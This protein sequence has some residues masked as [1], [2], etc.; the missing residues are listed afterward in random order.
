M[1]AKESDMEYITIK[2]YAIKNKIS[3]FN[4]MKLAKSGK[5]ETVTKIIDGKEQLL[6]KSD[7]KIIEKPKV[8]KVPTIEQ[9]AKEIEELKKRVAELEAK[10]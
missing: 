8:T 6:I 3:F 7:A 2:E 10:L 9:L 5:I 4:A 1:R